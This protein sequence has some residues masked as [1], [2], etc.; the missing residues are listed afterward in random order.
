MG[1][2][3]ALRNADERLRRLGAG[4]FTSSSGQHPLLLFM[5]CSDVFQCVQKATRWAVHTTVPLR[6]FVFGRVALL[7]DAVSWYALRHVNYPS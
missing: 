1:S 7:G 2:G 4:S 6:T 5:A 3:L